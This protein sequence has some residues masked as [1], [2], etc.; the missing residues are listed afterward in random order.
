VRL[1]SIGPYVPRRAFP[2]LEVVQRVY[3]RIL[4]RYID[5]RDRRHSK[6][7]GSIGRRT[8]KNFPRKD[9]TDIQKKGFK[10]ISTSAFKGVFPAWY[11]NAYH[12]KRYVIK[13]CSKYFDVLDYIP[14]GMSNQQD[15][16]VL[17][18]P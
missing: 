2:A 6:V 7:T 9:I 16:V 18:K 8:W 14:R 5:L 11:Q 1:K 10:F 15:V 4:F 17:Q 3:L 13:R 12:T